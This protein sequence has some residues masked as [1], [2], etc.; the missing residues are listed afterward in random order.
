MPDNLSQRL[1]NELLRHDIDMMRVAVSDEQESEA[2]IAGLTSV[3]VSRLIRRDPTAVA[4]GFGQDR[5]DKLIS[6]IRTIIRDEYQRLY[7]LE[8]A[9]L[10]E[11]GGLGELGELHH[12]GVLAGEHLH[13][14]EGTAQR[15][16][17]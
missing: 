7:K 13:D 1:A 3:L 10:I 6:E 4:K 15:P 16:A 5:L 12:G 17:D 11:A 2:A 8:R 9:H 14:R